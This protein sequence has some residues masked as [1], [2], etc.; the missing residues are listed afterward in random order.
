VVLE[1]QE[2]SAELA[3]IFYEND[4]AFSR[5]VSPQAAAEFNE[6]TDAL[7]KLRKDFGSLFEPML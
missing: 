1:N 7:Y 2:L 5:K 3:K 4:L 6:P